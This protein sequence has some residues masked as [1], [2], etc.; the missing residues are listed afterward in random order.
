[1]YINGHNNKVDVIQNAIDNIDDGNLDNAKDILIQLKEI[2]LKST[3]YKGQVYDYKQ[4]KFIPYAEFWA[5]K[6]SGFKESGFSEGIL[7]GGKADSDEVDS[8]EEVKHDNPYVAG[9]GI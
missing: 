1:M 8:D 3:V 6:E 4:D 2:E 5:Q 9:E 7:Y